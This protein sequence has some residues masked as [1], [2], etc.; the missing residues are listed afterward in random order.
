MPLLIYITM[1]FSPGQKLTYIWMPGIRT[2][3]ILKL[4]T[5]MWNSC[6]QSTNRAMACHLHLTPMYAGLF[7]YAFLRFWLQHMIQDY[8]NNLEGYSKSNMVQ[9]HGTGPYLIVLDHKYSGVML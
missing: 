4:T 9:D 5:T 6:C 2:N 1:A 8:I 7:L 3:R